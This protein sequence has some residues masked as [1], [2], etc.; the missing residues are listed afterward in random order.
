MNTI[1][2][3]GLTKS[4]FLI[5]YKNCAIKGEDLRNS[6]IAKM[7]NFLLGQSGSIAEILE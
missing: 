7:F 3:N 4:F 2:S 1:C 6:L 5:Y